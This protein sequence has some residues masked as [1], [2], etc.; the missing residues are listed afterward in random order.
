MDAEVQRASYSPTC[1]VPFLYSHVHNVIS[2]PARQ[3]R[4]F[5]NNWMQSELQT[6]RTGALRLRLKF[7]C[8]ICIVS[9]SF[10]EADHASIVKTRMGK[11]KG[12]LGGHWGYLC[13]FQSSFP[14]LTSLQVGWREQYWEI[15]AVRILHVESV[16]WKSFALRLEWFRN[17]GFFLT[18][19]LL[20]YN[21]T[22][23]KM[24][25]FPF[26]LYFVTWNL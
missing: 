10:A 23:M 3:N 26:I 11:A 13:T 8:N 7:W 20:F 15:S 17:G 6:V 9:C 22:I 5:V 16:E 14:S 25:Y 4:C 18:Q 2:P 12:R 24:Y 21:T 1:H 19:C